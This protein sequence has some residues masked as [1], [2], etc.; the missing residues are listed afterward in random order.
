MRRSEAIPS[1]G[2]SLVEIEGNDESVKGVRRNHGGGGKI[3]LLSN[4]PLAPTQGVIY[5]V[6]WRHSS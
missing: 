4:V 1:D 6:K 2:L 5:S 3:E